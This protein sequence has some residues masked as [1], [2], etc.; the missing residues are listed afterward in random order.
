MCETLSRKCLWKEA[1]ARALLLATWAI[2]CTRSS[3]M[4]HTDQSF[5]IVQARMMFQAAADLGEPGLLY[6]IP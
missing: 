5:A 6:F 1:T 3:H 2:A 4:L